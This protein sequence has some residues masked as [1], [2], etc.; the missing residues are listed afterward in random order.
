VSAHAAGIVHGG[1]E[2]I[3]AEAARL[4]A[5]GAVDLT[6]V[7]PGITSARVRSD[8]VDHSVRVAGGR[9]ECSCGARFGCAHLE[10]VALVTVPTVCDAVGIEAEP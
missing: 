10:A 2:T 9:W 1:A 7:T 3:E 4:L 8:G 5:T 6:F